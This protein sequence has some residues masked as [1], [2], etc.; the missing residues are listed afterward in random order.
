MDELSIDDLLTNPELEND[1]VEADA[2]AD[3]EPLAEPEPELDDN[4]P[5]PTTDE[6]A[7]DADD[8]D[9]YGNELNKAERTYTE[10][11][12]NERINQAIR[13]RLARLERNNPQLQQQAQT[14]AKQ[15]F[16][17]DANS[18]QSWQQQLEQF[19]E[20][21][22][23]KVQQKQL[24]QTQQLQEQQAQAAFQQKFQNGMQRFNDFKEVVTKQPITDS[25][26]MAT[27]GM[28]DPAAF[29]YTAAKRAPDEL[30]R[31]AQIS[32]PYAQMFEVGRLEERLRKQKA[33]TS[34]PRPLRKTQD[35]ANL[36]LKD[37]KDLSIEDMIALDEKRRRDRM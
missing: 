7:D 11:E 21:T 12:V 26:L 23:T 1:D 30:Q 28:S 2:P 31:I 20:Q 8:T 15:N 3:E 18:N 29:V 35:D 16:E 13:E 19:V 10:A 4:A 17:Y 9:E 5:A 32:D 25:M 33:P 37:K 24:Q 27:R 36:A 6:A 34:A 22:L 14:E